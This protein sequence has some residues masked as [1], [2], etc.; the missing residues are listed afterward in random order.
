MVLLAGIVPD[1]DGLGLGVDLITRHTAHPTD[2]WGDLHHV[3]GHNLCFGL[4]VA[5]VTFMLAQHHWR[6]SMLA[7]LSFHLHLLG[8]VLGGQGPDGDQ[9]PIPYLAPFS[10]SM[11]W[12]WSGQ[13][14]LNAWPNFVI[15]AV[16]LAVMFFI[17]W[18]RGISPLECLSTRANDALVGALRRRFGP[19]SEAAHGE[20][21]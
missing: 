17:A 7:L 16:L 4:V 20:C 8:D 10:Q 12:V 15:T 18:R 9:W 14:Q 21:P 3:L 11:Q 13:W 6:A 19:P 1:I 5:A 2:Y